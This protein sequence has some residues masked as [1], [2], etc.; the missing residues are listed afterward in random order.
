[1]ARKNNIFVETVR[2]IR[3]KNE[4]KYAKPSQNMFMKLLDIIG[5]IIF[6]WFGI[7]M[8]IHIFKS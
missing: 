2:D 7:A 3:A 5:L 6:L 1:M 4:R 8:L